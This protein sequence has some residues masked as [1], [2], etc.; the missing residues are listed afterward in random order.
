MLLIFS[1]RKCYNWY[2]NKWSVV[3][4]TFLFTRFLLNCCSFSLIAGCSQNSHHFLFYLLLLSIPL[5]KFKGPC[6]LYVGVFLDFLNYLVYSV[7]IYHLDLEQFLLIWLWSL[8]YI[9]RPYS[10]MR[11]I[12]TIT[13][14]IIIMLVSTIGILDTTS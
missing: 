11:I 14:F 6:N 2:S 12:N 8:S 13:L 10:C 1:P 9:R 4:Q 3:K 5:W 7:Y